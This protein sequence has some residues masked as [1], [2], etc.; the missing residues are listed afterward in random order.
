VPG[1]L[2]GPVLFAYE[3]NGWMLTL[4][5]YGG[6]HRPTDAEGRLELVRPLRV[7]IASP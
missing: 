7:P 3:N 6:H 4:F 2:T 1:R 5:G